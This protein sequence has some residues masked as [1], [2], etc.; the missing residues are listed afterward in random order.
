MHY[1]GDKKIFFY[2]CS[3]FLAARLFGGEDILPRSIIKSLFH[4]IKGFALDNVA[5]LS[6]HIRILLYYESCAT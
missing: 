2:H 3:N 6:E 4:H 1:I 5:R